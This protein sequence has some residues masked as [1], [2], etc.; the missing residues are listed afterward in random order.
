MF[1]LPAR[2][3]SQALFSECTGSQT[4][5]T[6]PARLH[7]QALCSE[8]TGSPTGCLP[9]LQECTLMHYV[10]IALVVRLSVYLACKSAL[11]CT[12]F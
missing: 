10:L 11:S 4:V 3:H 1:T 9:C 8:C 2:V 6:L 12:M 5:F 7:S